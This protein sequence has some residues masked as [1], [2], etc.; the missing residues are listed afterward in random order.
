MDSRN[1]NSAFSP[2]TD[3]FHSSPAGPQGRGEKSGPTAATQS[4]PKQ[5]AQM[6]TKTG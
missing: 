5:A 4:S 1:F 6:A 3:I 2:E